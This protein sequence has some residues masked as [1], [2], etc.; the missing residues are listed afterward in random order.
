MKTVK[1]ILSLFLSVAMVV[2]GVN[3]GM[4][5]KV[6]AAETRN[7]QYYRENIIGTFYGTDGNQV[8]LGTSTPLSAEGSAACAASIKGTTYNGDE[9]SNWGS[10]RYGCLVFQIPNDMNLTNLQS[11]SLTLKI[12]K[13]SNLG[14]GGWMKVALYETNNPE[15]TSGSPEGNYSVKN[16]YHGVDSAFWSEERVSD[17]DNA[18]N[19]LDVH[20]DV[21]DAVENVDMQNG[22][23]VLRVQV[24]RAGIA[25]NNNTPASLTIDA[26]TPTN[27]SVEYVDEQGKK[28]Q[29]DKILDVSVGSRYTY[30]I[31]NEEKTLTID[32]QEYKYQA[33]ASKTEINEV[34]V[35]GDEGA[36]AN[37]KITL[38]YK[39]VE[40]VSAIAPSTIYAIEGN[41]PILPKQV[42]ANT[43]ITGYTSKTNVT[44]DI[45]GVEW[46]VGKHTVQGMAAGLEGDNAKVAAVVQVYECDEAIDEKVTAAHTDN[47]KDALHMLS[48]QYK[49]EIIS[50]FDITTTGVAMNGDKDDK[51]FIYLDSVVSKNN[52][53]WNAGGAM[54]HFGKTQGFFNVRAGDGSGGSA[55]N[56][57][58]SNGKAIYDGES[59]YHV[60]VEMNSS[61]S[62]GVY[63]IYVTDPDGNVNEVGT[64]SNGNGFRKYNNGVIQSYYTGRGAYEVTNH[65]IY[66]KSGFA[67]AVVDFCAPDGTK[68][69]ESVSSKELPE[70]SKVMD[71][72]IFTPKAKDGKIYLYDAGSSGWDM[73]SNGKY[74]TGGTDIAATEGAAIPDAGKE[75]HFIGNYKEA[76]F[77]G[78]AEE[79][80]LEAV[81]GKMPV[82]PNTVKATYEGVEGAIETGVTWNITEQDVAAETPDGQPRT[83]TGTFVNGETVTATLEV[84]HAYLLANYTFD[85]ENPAKDSTGRH[86]DAVL[87]NVTDGVDGV[88][89]GS[90]AVTL[91][92]G[93]NGTSYV[94]LPDDLLQVPGPNRADRVTQDDITISMF[95][96]REINGNS[97]AL[98]LHA[99]DVGKN[100]PTGHLGLINK[101][102]AAV[103]GGN[104]GAPYFCFE[105][106]TGGNTTGKLKPAGDPVTPSK[107][108]VHLAI[109]TNGS[110][111][112]AKM[113]Q[114]GV[115]VAENEGTIVKPSEL[116]AQNNYLGRASWLDKD[117]KATF[118]DFAVYNG[119]LT[120]AEIQEIA[121][122]RLC[123]APVDD[124]YDNLALTLASGEGT[125]DKTQITED[126]SLPTEMETSDGKSIQ[127]LKITWES[128]N[129]AI[130][131]NGKV[132]RPSKKNGNAAVNLKATIQYGSYTRTKTFASLTVLALD[133]A[134]FVEFDEAYA[135]AEE[136]YE[137]AKAENIYTDASLAALKAKLEEADA[138]KATEGKPEE[139][140]DEVDAMAAELKTAADVLALKSFE[141]VNKSLA[142]WYPLD[143]VKTKANDS[144][145]KGCHGTAA[146]SV[147]F[148]RESGATFNGGKGLQNCIKLPAESL[149][150]LN[151]T[152]N[153]TFSFWA[154][155][156]RGGKSNAFG[157]GSG[158]SFG[159]NGCV[160]GNNKDAQFFYVTTH[161]NGE[162]YSS[163]NTK[164]W[165]SPST[166]KTTAPAKGEWH[167][168]TSVISGKTLTLYVDGAKVGE[169]IATQATLTEIWNQDP[170]TR[171]MYIGNCS[172]GTQ[173]EA[174]AD[175]DYKGSI[176]DVRV[177]NASLAQEQVE[178]AYRYKD[179]VLPMKYAKDVL[180]ETMGARV[181]D[182]GTVTLN[183]TNLSTTNGVLT[184]PG[185]SYG[186]AKVTS[187]VS[188]DNDVINATTGVAAIPSAKGQP[189]KQ[190]TLT[191]TISIGEG[192]G[193]E[194]SQVVF[195]CEVY[196]KNDT[197]TTALDQ[198]L[199]GIRDENLVEAE[200]TA[201]SWKQLSDAM[202]EAQ[203]QIDDPG[204]ATEVATVK[205]KLEAARQGLKK[206]GDMELLQKAVAEAEKITAQADYTPESW[207]TF[208][209]A[210]AAAKEKL[211]A[212]LS[213]EEV[214]DL[215]GALQR[216][217]DGLTPGI[218]QEV[219]ETE[220]AE[221]VAAIASVNELKKVNYTNE[222]WT[223]LQEKVTALRAVQKKANATKNEVKA[224][225]KAV[226]D[227]KDQL[228]PTIAQT[229]DADKIAELNTEFANATT[230]NGQMKESDYTVESWETYQKAYDAMKKVADRLADNAKK[231]SVTKSE[232]DT[233]IANLKAAA[234]G[235]VRNVDKTALETAIAGCANLKATDYTTE[236][237]NAFQTALDAA[238][239]ALA[240]EDATQQ[241]VDGA[242]AELNA[243]K[244]ALANSA[245]ASPV[246]VSSIKLT[247]TYKN[248]AAGKKT[249]IKA[250]VNS[251]AA[252]NGV[253]FSSSNSKWATVNAKTGVVSTKKGGAGK[254]VTITATAND[255]GKKKQN[256]KIKIMKGSVTKIVVKKK[257]LKVKAGKK[258]IIKATAKT[259]GRPANKTLSYKSSQTKWAT[260]NNK[261]K[262]TTKKAGKGKTVKI[263]ISS[264]DGTNKKA[265]V[266][267]KI[268]K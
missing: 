213:V 35:S 111:G 184:L 247:A 252:D 236:T 4:P 173:P 190:A 215:T 130:R 28:I 216:A 60:R 42:A 129:V 36:S 86:A 182:D 140:S 5:S 189:H 183:V 78:Q 40:L 211:E 220:K 210:L 23:L 178:A 132:V 125:F 262:V 168:I 98:T 118:D 24:P 221:I 261:G 177:Y 264:T 166:I 258:V 218:G 10:P 47:G 141:E 160:S 165:S 66:W 251:D 43:N 73:D 69:A 14:N 266:K 34:M 39:K 96:N 51:A 209:A 113:Y 33:D 188:S 249:T 147:T 156:D 15:I 94:K 74:E 45:S 198:A 50:E 20:F 253:T 181:E 85:G 80:K 81:L 135:Q 234:E 53:V 223:A 240:K 101:D 214:T 16:G 228:V 108:W 114:D 57:P 56:D 32:G 127:G 59:V 12:K 199:Q 186:G 172:Y 167:H 257:T 106:R 187:W 192:E 97:F 77:E 149:E 235:L 26:T 139:D 30:D 58:A 155:D 31:P 87:T 76:T 143:N 157:I 48:G 126:L 225:I 115:L 27:A 207:G 259:K 171:G 152:D 212:D 161:D 230:A 55:A 52:D 1:R 170:K 8:S 265:V 92:G 194:T 254:T 120:E 206:R 84:K 200:Y 138:I 93:N 204:D 267:I 246:L 134:S 103:S 37:N 128:D 18:N 11:A 6:Q 144:S 21:K 62:P 137:T 205:S 25:F 119:L 241:E 83:V 202:K 90:K 49:G 255:A 248:V 227:A 158:D 63:R 89:S 222:S 196:Y 229:P 100:N 231:G 79:V 65:K 17:R 68:L 70:S 191:A 124:I 38:V 163:V 197:D 226:E 250:T 22:R 13:V 82:L 219:G 175:A 179:E 122:G 208:Q 7:E 185:T 217:I 41:E 243:K 239:A 54:L 238:K 3:L 260:V 263:T 237:W 112:T 102:T 148:S 153:M 145:G 256:I 117:Y 224:A 146:A 136:R 150:R 9:T 201:S 29:G 232:I 142:A 19:L 133:G 104:Y 195:Q 233:V 2:T 154:K 64:N 99:T 174:K 244:A 162:L 75:I 72:T 151:V 245:A 169:T 164:Y 193:A 176:R 107:Q 203:S 131:T 88:D 91:K 71:A 242:L 116:L 123:K 44:W 109:V 67:T 159:S 61:T 121:N 268:T 105:Y 110:E 46:T 95:V 180:I